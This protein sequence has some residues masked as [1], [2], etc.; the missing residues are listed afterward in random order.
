MSC[1]LAE[2][3]HKLGLSVL[4]KIKARASIISVSVSGGGRALPPGQGGADGGGGHARN[5]GTQGA[6]EKFRVKKSLE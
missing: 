2:V 4:V 5:H 3:T 1:L 6:P